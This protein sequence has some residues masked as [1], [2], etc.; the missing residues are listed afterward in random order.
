MFFN[1]NGDFALVEHEKVLKNLMQ[2]YVLI[3]ILM[4]VKNEGKFVFDKQTL[5]FSIMTSYLF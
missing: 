4:L 2:G 3:T 5:L 1:C